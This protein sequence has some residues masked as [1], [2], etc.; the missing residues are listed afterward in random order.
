MRG[1][2]RAGSGRL[3]WGQVPPSHLPVP[4]A[5]FQQFLSDE[6]GGRRQG[7]QRSEMP[8]VTHGAPAPPREVALG[9]PG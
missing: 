8:K 1:G 4:S 3:D 5:L 7:R 2:G 6:G 9:S